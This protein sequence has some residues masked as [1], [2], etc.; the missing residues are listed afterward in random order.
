MGPANSGDGYIFPRAENVGDLLIQEINS[1]SIF[2]I[3]EILLAQSNLLGFLKVYLT[4][5]SFQR[6]RS[7]TGYTESILHS[8]NFGSQWRVVVIVT[9]NHYM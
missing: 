9:I 3:C 1:D 5:T 8:G 6:S 4:P 2:Y 7:A